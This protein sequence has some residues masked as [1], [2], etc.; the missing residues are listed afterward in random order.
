MFNSGMIK[1]AV[2]QAKKVDHQFKLGAVIF[3]KSKIVSEGKN[4]AQRS[5]RKLHPRYMKWSGSLHAEQ[6]AV[7]N[8]FTDLKGLEML[9]VRIGKSGDFRLAKPCEHCMKYLNKIGLKRV[10]YTIDN[11][12]FG[13]IERRNFLD[14]DQIIEVI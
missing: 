5:K 6:D 9:V 7:L 13:V 14:S 4:T 1:S 10:Y 3:D 12:N 8:A 11:T 2:K